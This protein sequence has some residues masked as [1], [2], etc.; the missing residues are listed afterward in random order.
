MYKHRILLLVLSVFV[1]GVTAVEATADANQ[2]KCSEHEWLCAP[3]E[4]IS[5][6]TANQTRDS[7]SGQS[8]NNS[9]LR[10][11]P[12]TDSAGKQPFKIAEIGS[13]VYVRVP[14]TT[15]AH[16]VTLKDGRTEIAKHLDVWDRLP[17]TRFKYGGF[18]APGQL[19][20]RD[21]IGNERILYDCVMNNLPCV[22]LDPSVSLDGKRVYFAVYS[23][24]DFKLGWRDGVTLPNMQLGDKGQEAKLYVA[25]IASGVV[26][27]LAHKKGD[28]DTNPVE[29]PDGKI[30]F[31]SDRGHTIEPWLDRIGNSSQYEPQLYIADADG[32]NAKNIS[33]HELATA[34][35]PYVLQDGNVIYS[36]FLKSHNLRYGSTN[37]GVNWPGTLDNGW[38]MVGIDREGG[39]MTWRL[40]AHGTRLMDGGRLKTGK[41]QHFFGQLANGDVC[42]ANYYR[43]NNL[44][45]GDVFCFPPQGKGIEGRGPQFIP[46][47]IY[48][49]ASWSKSNDEASLPDAN[50]KY[51]GKIGYPEGLSNGQIML[52][53]GRGYC[54]QVSGTVMGIEGVLANEPNT[55]GCDVGIYQ[56]TV[57]PSNSMD[58][59]AL[60]VDDPRW[61]EFAAREVKSQTIPMPALSKSGSDMCVLASSDAG[62]AETHNPKPYKFNDEY[63]N[64]A[65]GGEIDGLDHSEVVGIKFWEVV[66]NQKEPRSFK[67]SIGNKIKEL[68]TVSLLDD[69]S[70]AVELPCETPFLMG[71]V[72]KDGLLTKRDQIPQSLRTGEKR[73]CTGC[74]LHTK[75]G[76]PYE[77]SLAFTAAPVKLLAAIPAPTYDKDIK[78]ILKARCAGCHANDVPLFDYDN[79][80][81]D[82]AQTAVPEGMKLQVSTSTN[83]TRK[84]GLQRPLTSKYVNSMYARESLLY[85]KAAN[86]RTDG[87]TDSQYP[88]DIDFGADHPTGITAAELN[89]LGRW[90]DSGAGNDRP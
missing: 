44:G 56:T 49:V 81:W 50:G 78:P 52:T 36:S 90:L 80:V 87:R 84:Y 22:P 3:S 43:A 55:L 62:T 38:S 9:E 16:E 23:A 40:G 35:H 77:Q 4:Y 29:L 65:N 83:L 25:D 67:N 12:A 33:P 76:R 57:I 74:H 51:Q 15:T 31:S 11:K 88:N 5:G 34:M 32:A 24:S 18:V 54:T 17:D 28:R 75:P 53:V 71:G 85:W 63:S 79:L 46:A 30:M 82:F 70:F 69:K 66:P 39:D 89:L 19:V 72:D 10:V 7:E 8:L 86:K 42:T 26:T 14:R 27:A 37:G 48:N 61:H 2:Y 45:L 20:H 47:G 41:A 13:I 59:M 60:I 58:D 73:V 68:G 64:A 6:P 21:K 1:S